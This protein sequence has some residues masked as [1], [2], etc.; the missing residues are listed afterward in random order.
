MR[1]LERK[2]IIPLTGTKLLLRGLQ[3]NMVVTWWAEEVQGIPSD[4]QGKHRAGTTH[5]LDAGSAFD[6][7]PKVS[8]S[9]ES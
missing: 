5:V 3:P 1:K 4:I 2:L 6:R 7:Y 9:L 8:I